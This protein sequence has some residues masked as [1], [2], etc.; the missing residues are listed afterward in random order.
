MSK[1]KTTN[2]RR[3]FIQ[4]ISSVSAEEL[5]DY[6]K[7]HGKPPKSVRLYHLIKKEDNNEE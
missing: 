2:K 1:Q 4:F 7:S 6:I 3:D 5:N